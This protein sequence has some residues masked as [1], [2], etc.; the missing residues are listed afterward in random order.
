[1]HSDFSEAMS[2][3]SSALSLNLLRQYYSS[4]FSRENCS[5]IHS[6]RVRIAA[7]KLSTWAKKVLVNLPDV[8]TTGERNFIHSRHI[9]AC[10]AV[11]LKFGSKSVCEEKCRRSW[12]E[13]DR[14]Y[15]CSM[16]VLPT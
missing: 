7:H 10:Y 11:F 2:G 9:F 4:V 8:S 5:L 1:M 12:P 15:G 16:Q 6:T 14:I 3:V 13:N